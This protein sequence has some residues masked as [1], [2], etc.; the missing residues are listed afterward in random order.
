MVWYNPLTWRETQEEGNKG[1]QLDVGLLCGNPQCEDPLIQ[2]EVMCFNPDKRAIY[3]QGSCTLEALCWESL[4]SPS[5]TTGNLE[6]I[7]RKKA[8][9]L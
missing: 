9:Q 1:V 8:Y 4:Q 7:K 3:H 6:S 5:L 2:G